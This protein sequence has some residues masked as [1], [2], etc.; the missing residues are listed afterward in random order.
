MQ[1]NTFSDLLQVLILFCGVED[2]DEDGVFD[3]T[4]DLKALLTFDDDL[5]ADNLL[6]LVIEALFV[7]VL[8]DILK[9]LLKKTEM[10]FKQ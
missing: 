3:L 7:G 4:G 8:Q 10:Y 1:G 6:C 2:D 9:V 5:M